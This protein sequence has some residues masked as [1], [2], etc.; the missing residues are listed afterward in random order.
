MDLNKAQSSSPVTLKLSFPGHLQGGIGTCGNEGK[1]MVTSPLESTM[2]QQTGISAA[3]S[4]HR[5][6]ANSLPGLLQRNSSGECLEPQKPQPLW[7]KCKGEEKD[8]PRVPSCT[9]VKRNRVEKERRGSAGQTHAHSLALSNAFQPQKHLYHRP[10]QL[11][12]QEKFL[13]RRGQSGA[14]TLHTRSAEGLLSQGP[15]LPPTHTHV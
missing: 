1:D 4:Y 11:S 10:P 13:W 8:E 12:C 2:V 7:P 9:S 15:F 3:P 14:M 5:L 6:E